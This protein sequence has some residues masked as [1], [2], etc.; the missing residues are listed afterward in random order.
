MEEEQKSQLQFN[1]SLLDELVLHYL[2]P[3][4]AKDSEFFHQFKK[5][6]DRL[7]SIKQILINGEIQK[8][9]KS[10]NE[11]DPNILDQNKDIYF[12]IK[13]E[14]F[15]ELIKKKEIESALNFAQ[16]VLEP[17]ALTAHPESYNK[18][19]EVLLYLIYEDPNLPKWI[20]K[21]K[22]QREEL[23]S[24]IYISFLKSMNVE[25]TTFSYLIRYLVAI[26]NLYTILSGKTSK[27]PEIETFIYGEKLPQ[28]TNK[29][30]L[31]S[32]PRIRELE[33]SISR[34]NL[35]QFINALNLTV[36]EAKN[37]LVMS[38]NDMD[39]A[40]KT[41]LL[42]IQL[43]HNLLIKLSFDYCQ[44]RGLINNSNETEKSQQNQKEKKEF[45]EIIK[46]FRSEIFADSK[47]T[48][49][50]DVIINEIEENIP[51]FF[52]KRKNL[53]FRLALLCVI[54]I[55]EYGEFE[56]AWDYANEKKR[57]RN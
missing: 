2:F 43:N 6:M 23:F 41:E 30:S 32:R 34:N 10:L 38:E 4:G 3:S 52:K 35:R 49:P 5:N 13:R 54:N 51:N 57:K 46:S 44:I 37:A 55:L 56:K 16:K 50:I 22:E 12:L 45:F 31:L 8:V 17:L 39:K 25:E 11:I 28:D 24:K 9:I 20:T 18:F 1:T 19:K 47:L 42:R 40:F 7:F 53:K 27:Y 15:I 33:N 48:V 29:L 26:H 14:E 36:D 21:L